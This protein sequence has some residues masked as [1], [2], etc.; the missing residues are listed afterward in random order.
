MYKLYTVGARTEPCGTPASISRGLDNSPSVVTLNFLS[1]R[2]EL[3]SFINF[4]ENCN[5]DSLYCK[6][7][8]YFVSKAF[9]ISK[10][11]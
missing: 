3:I 5:F 1:V 7:G 2:N 6:P 9:S 8:N 4:A 10:K 11:P